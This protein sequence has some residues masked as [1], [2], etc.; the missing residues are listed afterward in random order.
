MRVDLPH[1]VLAP[2]KGFRGAQG[3]SGMVRDGQGCSGMFRGVQGSSGMPRDAQSA[4]VK[5]GCREKAQ[6]AYSMRI[7][8]DVSMDHRIPDWLDSFPYQ[9]AQKDPIQGAGKPPLLF[10]CNL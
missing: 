6:P 5:T 2:G 7:L 10:L 8:W 3:C 9:M 1:K 4:H